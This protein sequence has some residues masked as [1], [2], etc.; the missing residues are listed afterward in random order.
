MKR[1]NKKV[2]VEYDS[3]R[4]SVAEVSARQAGGPMT[5][6][7]AM[8]GLKAMWVIQLNRPKPPKPLVNR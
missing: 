8:A 1:I 3:G 2:T 7:E 5:S 4:N 6:P